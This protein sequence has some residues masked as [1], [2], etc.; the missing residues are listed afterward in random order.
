[1][2]EIAHQ[3]GVDK[4]TVSR[5]LSGRYPGS[6]S[7]IKTEQILKVANE[8][9]YRVDPLAA[10]L[11]TQ[12]TQTIGV[13]IPQL[14]D[15]VLAMIFAAI[16]TEATAAGY[17]VIV[18]NTGDSGVEQRRRIE[19]L[20]D[21]RV[22][23]L[24]VMTGHLGDEQ[25]FDQLARQG[26]KFVL[27]NRAV[28]QHPVIRA[29]DRDGGRQATQHLLALG[30]RRIGVIAGPPYAPTAVERVHGYCDAMSEA[31]AKVD[32]DLIVHSGVQVNDG[33]DATRRLLSLSPPPT[34]VF[35]VNDFAAMGALSVIRD[36]GHIPGDDIAVIGYNDIPLC[37]RLPV[38]LSSIHH[39]IEEIGRLAVDALL[40]L[41]DGR[42]PESIALPVQLR[43]RQSSQPPQ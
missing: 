34:A 38:P 23:G 19:L 14:T 11:R 29:D 27:A 41:L 13:L 21:R 3:A 22:D 18:A 25:Y 39:P 4:S 5:V 6:A 8:L 20:E 33:E 26:L 16:D 36:A 31:G 32:P 1:M 42:S 24:I 43:A 17:Q 37:T 7:L 9:G 30:H 35:A 10:S 15:I 28:G 40:T 12:R 2:K